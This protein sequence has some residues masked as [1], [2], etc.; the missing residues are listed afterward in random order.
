M[1]VIIAGYRESSLKIVVAKRRNL[2]IKI[3]DLT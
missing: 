1:T 2:D 3:M